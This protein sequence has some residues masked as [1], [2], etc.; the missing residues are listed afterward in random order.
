MLHRNPSVRPCKSGIEMERTTRASCH[1][2]IVAATIITWLGFANAAFAASDE[3]PVGVVELFTS[4]GCSACPSADAVLEN[5]ARSGNLVALSYHVDYWDYLGW[6][7]T[8]ATPALTARQYAYR[9][10]LG[11]MGVYTPQ[12]VLNGRVDVNGAHGGAILAKLDS[13]A[14]SGEG[15]QIPVRIGMSKP[16]KFVIDVGEGASPTNPVRLEIVYFDP[17]KKI[18]ISRG[19]NGGRTL[20]YVNVVRDLETINMWDG[21]PLHIEMPLSQ[22]AVKG[23]AGCAVLLQEYVGGETPGAILGAAIVNSE[24]TR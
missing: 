14:A 19:E 10:S 2:V 11:T 22:L 8:L 13:M 15:M 7:D 17:L 18:T 20:S 24:H 4:Q 21:K 12:A 3:K 9:T 1:G 5:L 6:R 23:A 16:S